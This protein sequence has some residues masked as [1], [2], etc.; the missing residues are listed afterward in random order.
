MIPD[1]K[2]AASFSAPD[3]AAAEGETSGPR[4]SPMGFFSVDC[5]KESGLKS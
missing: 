5:V 3:K 2:S 4:F 1:I